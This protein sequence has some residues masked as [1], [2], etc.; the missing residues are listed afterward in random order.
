MKRIQVH[1]TGA[2]EAFDG[3]AELWLEGEQIGFTHYDPHDGHLLLRIDPRRD[4]TPL[5]VEIR[6]LSMALTEAERVL[7]VR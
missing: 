7:A 2:E 4:G 6:S 1:T 5:S 3:V